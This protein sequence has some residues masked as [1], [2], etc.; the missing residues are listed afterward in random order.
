M[1]RV[2]AP[3][4]VVRLR[5]GAFFRRDPSSFQNGKVVQFMISYT[6]DQ[7]YVDGH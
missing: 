1:I 5:V 4:P 7:I 3:V 6:L 2:R